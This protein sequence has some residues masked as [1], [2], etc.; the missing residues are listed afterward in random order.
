MDF[1][2]SLWKLERVKFLTC[3]QFTGHLTWSE[4]QEMKDE[5]FP[6][7]FWSEASEPHA[8]ALIS[9]LLCKLLL[10]AG[11]FSSGDKPARRR[12]RCYRAEPLSSW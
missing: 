4:E 3:G 8:A 11:G 1:W 7:F 6:E 10:P 9:H 12:R 5:I 2:S